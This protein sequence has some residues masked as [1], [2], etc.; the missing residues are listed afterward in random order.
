MAGWQKQY[1]DEIFECTLSLRKDLDCRRHE[2]LILWTDGGYYT[3][4]RPPLGEFSSCPVCCRF[5]DL[6]CLRDINK[7]NATTDNSLKEARENFIKIGAC[8]EKFVAEAR[9]PLETEL[10]GINSNM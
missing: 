3:F 6:E 1:W 10:K 2:E 5:E 4:E 7:M 9:R 8:C